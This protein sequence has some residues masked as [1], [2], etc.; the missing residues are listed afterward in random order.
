MK[1]LITTTILSVVSVVIVFFAFNYDAQAE[2]V[3]YPVSCT[4]TKKKAN[5]RLIVFDNAAKGYGL[6]STKQTSTWSDVLYQYVNIPKGKYSV[7]L[8]SFDGYDGRSSVAQ[9]N[10][11]FWVFLA[12]NNGTKSVAATNESGDVPDYKEQAFWTGNVGNIDVG[13]NVDMISLRHVIPYKGAHSNS[14]IPVC[15][16]LEDITPPPLTPVNGQCNSTYNGQVLTS[17][18]TTNLCSV[19]TASGV[20]GLGTTASPWT[21]TCGGSSGGSTASCSATQAKTPVN[22]QCNSTY[23]GQILDEIP[24]VGSLCTQGIESAITGTG[25]STNPWTWACDGSDGGS[26]SNCSAEEKTIASVPSIQIIKDDNDNNDD[27]QTVEEGETA[28]FTITVTNNGDVD[29]VNVVVTDALAP[30]CNKT[31][32]DLAIGKTQTYTCAIDNVTNSFTNIAVVDGEDNDGT[33]VDDEDDSDVVVEEPVSGASINIDKNDDGNKDDIQVVEEGQAATFVITVTNDGDEQL[34]NIV[35]TDA[36]APNCAKNAGEVVTL[37]ETK[38]GTGHNYLNPDESFDYTCTDENIEDDYTNI[39]VTTGTSTSGDVTDDDD[40]EVIVGVPC[41]PEIRIVKDDNDNNDDTQT[42]EENGTAEFTITVSNRGTEGLTDIVV[43]DVLA[44]NCNR[45]AEEVRALIEA[46]YGAGHDYLNPWESF[47][48]TCTDENVDASYTNIAVVT[49]VG[50]SGD[51]TD[52]DDSEVI[53]P[54]ISNNPS[55]QIIKDDNDNSDDT[56]TVEEGE[57]ATF[58]IKVT[59]NGDVDLVNVVVTDA[60]APNCDKNIGNL[61]IGETQTY[62]CT[63]D[64]V[65]NSF[66]NIAVVDGED[67]DGTDVDDEDQSDVVVI[68]ASDPAITIIKDDDDVDNHDDTQI[69]NYGETATFNIYVK[70]TGNVRLTNVS[71]TDNTVADCSLTTTEAASLINSK[72]GHTYLEPNESFHYSCTDTNVTQG[73][74]NTATTEG[75]SEGGETV[76]NTDTSD[77]IVDCN[78]TETD[79]NIIKEARDG[80]DHQ[81]IDEGDDAHFRITVENTGTSRLNEIS[82]NDAKAS[83]CNLTTSEAANLI[84]NKYGH[85]YLD[86]NESF[87]YECIDE[88]VDESYTNVAIVTGESDESTDQ[89]FDSTEID[90]E[91]DDVCNGS[92]GD[93]VWNDRDK[94]GVQDANEEGISGVRLK[95]YNGNDVEKDNTNSQGFYE[96][97]NL[98]KGEYDVVV[99]IETLPEGCYQTYDYDGNLDHS[100]TVNLSSG[101]DFERADF[102]YYCPSVVPVVTPGTSSPITGAGAA[103]GGAATIFASGAAWLAQKRTALKAGETLI[104]FTK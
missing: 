45:N 82:V 67:G 80:S 95:L 42:V 24:P 85:T 25:T 90:V 17:K 7:T 32:G 93:F 46:K 21:W 103:A 55:I 69:V 99:A 98:C 91:R 10:E 51:V 39:A 104:K 79:V 71:V 70:N 76:N 84:D 18:P 75:T 30:N 6:I 36:L 40:S 22:G 96:F 68:D 54:V 92:I 27:T 5:D 64:N 57:T 23:S 29:L 4:L 60:L 100:T 56:Q 48:Y 81:T 1:K 15:M 44:P 72:Y 65:T 61:A 101:E 62:T 63:I 11:K 26:S 50:T 78:C 89:D 77:V 58:T 9:P 53:V 83:D 41:E 12:S 73:Y 28:T 34:T 87:S 19:G 31:I 2:T 52:D 49:G 35:V 3:H 97:N 94:D 59:N 33:G 47:D 86:P 8:Q 102:G 37:I 38:Y 14:H 74:T 66:T 88:N 20:S 16:L 13:E 43:T